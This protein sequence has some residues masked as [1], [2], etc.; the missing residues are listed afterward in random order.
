MEEEE[1]VPEGPVTN[2]W[3]RK[4]PDFKEEHNPHGMLEE[5]RFATLFPKYRE[6]YLREVWPLV[7]A[8]LS[9]FKIKCDLDVIE[10]EDPTRQYRNL[11]LISSGS[12]TVYTSRKTWDPFII[13]K[14]KLI[15]HHES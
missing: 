4:V 6:K 13:I 12:M 5:S 10:G 1:S 8:K 3:A 15:D 14:V 7:Q 9:E 2:A 11:I